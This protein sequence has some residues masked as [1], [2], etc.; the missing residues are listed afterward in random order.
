MKK[1]LLLL[2]IIL[3]LYT[4]SNAQTD[5]IYDSFETFQLA[6]FP[7]GI[8]AFRTQVMRNVRYPRK[9]MQSETQGIVYVRF[10]IDEKGLIK[11]ATIQKDIG[12]G[13][14]EEALRAVNAV[15]T[16]WTPARDKDGK[17]VKMRYVLPVKF[18]LEGNVSPLQDTIVAPE[19]VGK[20]EINSET[21]ELYE[22]IYNHI[23]ITGVT[24]PKFKIIK[25]NY[26]TLENN[27]NSI[28]VSPNYDAQSITILVMEDDK[29]AGR[30]SFTVKKEPNPTIQAF[31]DG[32]PI[33]LSKESNKRVSIPSGMSI[34]NI[35]KMKF[36]ILP[37]IEFAKTF[38]REIE[39]TLHENQN[40]ILTRNTD[41]ILE[42]EPFKKVAQ[43]AK[44]GDILEII[45]PYI[46]KSDILTDI[47]TFVTLTVPVL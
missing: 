3:C 15:T 21:P 28:K 36:K 37:D 7:G 6:E 38:P 26:V 18:K 14:G 33:N 44:K 9:A 22:G 23:S 46:I 32:K 5:K 19:Y 20:V 30:K 1:L 11:D 29:L 13:C 8:H 31:I 47:T 16:L 25:G 4:K 43:K 12:Y 42:G 27:K 24:N 10:I 41:L 34:K 39:Y 40:Y 35:E 2:G 17:A 45:I